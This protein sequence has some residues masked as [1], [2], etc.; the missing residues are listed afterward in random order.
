MSKGPLVTIM[1]W[2]KG[3]GLRGGRL[4]VLRLD[5]EL[6]QS[7]LRKVQHDLALPKA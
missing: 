4:T 5:F 6:D 1:G 7:R 3:G 2:F